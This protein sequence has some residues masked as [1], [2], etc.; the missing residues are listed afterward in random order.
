MDISHA[1]GTLTTVQ[2][3]NGVMSDLTPDNWSV[4]GNVVTLAFPHFRDAVPTY[5]YSISGNRL[6]WTPQTSYGRPVA[7]STPEIL[8][9]HINT[10]V[11]Y[12]IKSSL[13]HSPASTLPFGYVILPFP[14]FLSYKKSPS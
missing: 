6:T 1:D 3:T 11:T 13:F 5:T 12:L 14:F 8:T 9:L 7:D 2:S 10:S 4:S